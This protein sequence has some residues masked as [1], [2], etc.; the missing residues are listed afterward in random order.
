M[1]LSTPALAAG[2]GWTAGMRS[3]AAPALLSRALSGRRRLRPLPQPAAALRSTLARRLLTAAAV[4]EI[5]GDKVPG[6]PDR[7]APPVLAGR[8]V[9]GALV[10]AAVAAAR[11]GPLLPSVL[12]GVGGAVASS[13]AML[14]VR[15]RLG[16]ALGLPDAAVA[17]A[18]DAATLALGRALAARA[19]A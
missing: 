14:A 9:S 6:V 7:T 4:G 18:E 8:I 16:D 2:L 17:L 13:Y 12:A 11:R 10:G 15:T 3:M 19:A 5:A 1:D